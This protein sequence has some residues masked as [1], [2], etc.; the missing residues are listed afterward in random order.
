[1]IY[2]FAVVVDT[3]KASFAGI[4]DTVNTCI[5][6]VIYTGDVLSKL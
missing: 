6:S 3:G 4:N 1:M 5:A 2:N